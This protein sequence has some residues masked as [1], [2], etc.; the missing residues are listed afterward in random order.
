MQFNYIQTKDDVKSTENDEK[1]NGDLSSFLASEDT[2]S[3]I[4]QEN[5]DQDIFAELKVCRDFY[6]GRCHKKAKL[7][8][9][10]H[11]KRSLDK[12]HAER[13]VKNGICR[14]H[15]RDISCKKGFYCKFSHDPNLLHSLKEKNG[16]C[17]AFMYGECSFGFA[18][19]FKHDVNKKYVP[20]CKYYFYDGYCMYGDVC[21]F[22]H[23]EY[24]KKPEF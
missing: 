3:A 15:F 18:C 7:C 12:F 14:D 19:H 23:F 16:D 9:Y 1:F 2:K 24:A 11:D 22:R 10:S 4:S 13:K 8:F 21:Q 5:D 6:F 20:K 17:K